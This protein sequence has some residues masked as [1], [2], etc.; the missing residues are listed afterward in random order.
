[1]IKL[2][3]IVTYFSQPILE[4]GVQFLA[5]ISEVSPFN[6][7]AKKGLKD[8]TTYL[9]PTKDFDEMV[10]N[11][12]PL[13]DKNGNTIAAL[14]NKDNNKGVAIEFNTKQLPVL[15]LWKNTDTLKQ[16]YVT[17]IEPGT[18]YAYPVNIERAQKR[19]KQIEAGQSVS[20][21]LTYSL[22]SDRLQVQKVEN[23]IKQIQGSTTVK[24]VEI[25]IAKEFLWPTANF[26][27]CWPLHT[28]SYN[29]TLIMLLAMYWY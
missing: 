1:M 13:S 16:G 6:D 20:F 25:P 7:Y 17:G 8:W 3:T 2:Y 26:S 27:C 4:E 12:K 9:G 11:L 24:Q 23:T 10:F 29:Q 22:L 18:S 15:T 14:V 28:S 19:V 5:P 21:D